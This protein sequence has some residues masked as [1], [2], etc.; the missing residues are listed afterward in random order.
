[1]RILITGNT[2]YAGRS[3]EKWLSQW[4]DKYFIEYVSL[5]NEEWKDKDFSLYDVVFH[6]A[7]IVHQKE[8]PEMEELYYKV[9]RDLTIELAN[10]AKSAGV[11]QFIFMSTLSVYGLVGTV[12]KEVMINKD[13]PCHPNSFY[14]K[15]K[16]EAEGMLER[17]QNKE[18]KVA[19]LRVPM[20]YG[21][22]C[23]GNYEQLRWITDKTPVFP[24]IN[25]NRSMIFIDNLSEFIRLLIDNQD[26]GLFFPQNQEYINTSYL[27]TLIAREKHKNMYLSKLLSLGINLLAVRI[28]VI[29]KV[30]GNLTIDSNL[31]N[32]G[33]YKYCVVDLVESVK[34][35]EKI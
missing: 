3:L 19:I 11:K 17:L 28:K 29:N 5:R 31:S 9:N 34:R 32:Y 8:K 27:V 6:V 7:A 20:I 23:P 21:P 4:P 25:N 14:G 12:G 18:F 16:L 2:S 30:F 13:T 24:R 35:C 26:R 22:N 15:S 1:M 10:K 33:D